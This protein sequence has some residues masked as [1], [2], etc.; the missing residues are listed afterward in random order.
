M[1]WSF[2]MK[3]IC[4]SLACAWIALVISICAASPS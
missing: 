3:R 1:A 4:P 2:S